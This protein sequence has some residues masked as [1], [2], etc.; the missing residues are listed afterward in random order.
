MVSARMNLVPPW[1]QF[2]LWMLT[3]NFRDY[4]FT[5]SNKIQILEAEVDIK[6]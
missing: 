1:S 2:E 6:F 5:Y 4:V 3:S